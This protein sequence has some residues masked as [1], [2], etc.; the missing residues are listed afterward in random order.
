MYHASETSLVNALLYGVSESSLPMKMNSLVSVHFTQI[1]G[2]E[3][4]VLSGRSIEKIYLREISKLRLQ[5][6]RLINTFP[7]HDLFQMIRKS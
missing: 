5:L 1:L 2:C 6:I 3:I 4:V 7:I